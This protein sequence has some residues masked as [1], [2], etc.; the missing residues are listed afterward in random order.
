MAPPEKGQAVLVGAGPGDEGLI[1]VL[2]KSWLQRADVVI[3][4]HLVNAALNRFAKPGAEI[5][6]AGKKA[7]HSTLSQ[8]EINSLIVQK[9]REGKTV[10]R[11][12]GGDPFIFGR[13]GEETE[14]L[15]QA[16]IPFTVVPGVTSPVGVSA[17]AG[18]PLTHRGLASNVSIITGSS[19]KGDDLPIEWEKI[20][21]RSGT[22]VFLMGARK[23]PRIVENLVRHGKPASTPVAV[24]QWGA[25]PRQ[26]TW[27]GTLETILD[28]AQEIQPPALTIIGEVVNLK[29]TVDWYETLPLFGKTV[30]VTRAGEQS[31]SFMGMLRERGAE[32]LSAPVIETH[33]PTDYS[34]LDAAIAKLESYD[35]IIFTSVNGVRWFM[36]RLHEKE[37][38]VR[39]L[40]GLRI[41]A[42]GSKTERA[43]RNLGVRVDLVPEKFVAE[44]LLESLGRE[45]V[46]GKRYLLPRAAVAR[47][48]LPKELRKLGAEVDV[49]PAYQTLPP[50]QLNPDA[51][52]RLQSGALDVVT[53][54]S[55]STVK[56]FIDLI[57]A[58][59]K[60]LL[61]KTVLACIGPVTAQTARDL[62]LQV[63]IEA[64]EYTVE[65][66]T[67]ALEEYFREK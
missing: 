36:R 19:E 14:A 29:Q 8:D 26:K 46:K 39:E 5:I 32:P 45:S 64:E 37:L 21:T 65:G 2:G 10:V 1:T 6:Y 51:L 13:G 3:Y 16:G 62:G 61:D 38:D 47:E 49:V 35:G 56:N 34:P 12:K 59:R 24:V 7:G 17:Y 31:E 23:L 9:A 52:D 33:P 43:V 60:V 18:I 42:I 48:I 63:A 28:S 40:K 30:A 50:D 25:T 57:G 67:S 53:F 15:K 44:S 55:S 4:D 41:C 27:T 58:D 20:A 54:T 66:L 11:L 22:L